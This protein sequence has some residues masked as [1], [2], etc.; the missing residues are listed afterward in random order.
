MLAADGREG[1]DRRS[2]RAA[3]PPEVWMCSK[4]KNH[5]NGLHLGLG[6]QFKYLWRG[7]IRR[8]ETDF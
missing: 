1:G 8:F 4:R 3:C 5:A 7:V 2:C 6:E